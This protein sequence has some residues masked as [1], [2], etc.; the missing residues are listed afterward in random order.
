MQVRDSIEEM[1]GA[2]PLVIQL[3]IGAE[4]QLEGVIDLIKM[5]EI[6]YSGDDLGAT[7]EEREIRDD[8]KEEAQVPPSGSRI[9]RENANIQDYS[10][11]L[12]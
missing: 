11:G 9:D 7:W 6:V 5:K 10:L 4:D 12:S 3:P 2:D 8:L 1:L